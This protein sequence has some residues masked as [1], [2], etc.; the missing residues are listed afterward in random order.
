MLEVGM[1]YRP[2][3]ALYAVFVNDFLPTAEPVR[4]LSADNT[5]RDLPG[6]RHWFLP[7]AGWSALTGGERWQRLVRG[8]TNPL[9]TFQVLLA[10]RFP[11]SESASSLPW[12]DDKG[13]RYLVFAPSSYWDGALDWERPAVR[14]QVEKNRELVRRAKRFL[15]GQGVGL[16]VVLLPSK[17]MVYAPLVP[18]GEKLVTPSHRK[19]LERFTSAL[20]QDGVRLIDLREPL[21][22]AAAGGKRLYFAI[23]GHFDESGHAEAAR[24]LSAQI[25]SSFRR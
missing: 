6:D 3:H 14:A 5:F 10:L 13:G 20:R 8:L 9:Y 17:E 1:R 16:T 7:E 21:R 12:R 11:A 24:I 22:R 25:G 2:K 4:D 23:D 18:W 15:E 19:T